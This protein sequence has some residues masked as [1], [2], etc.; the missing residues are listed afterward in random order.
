MNYFFFIR[1]LR[2]DVGEVNDDDLRCGIG[3]LWGY[4]YFLCDIREVS[5]GHAFNG[6]ATFIFVC[7]GI[8]GFFMFFYEFIGG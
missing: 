3:F 1:V 5:I 6:F 4:A 7:D 2:L 8:D